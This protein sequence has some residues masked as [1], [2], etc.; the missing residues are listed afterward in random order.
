MHLHLLLAAFTAP[1]AVSGTCYTP[2]PAFPPI[3]RIL[4]KQH[5]NQL[6]QIL[7]NLA[8]NILK[9]PEGWATNKTS[10]SVQVTSKTQTIW[11]HYYTAPILGEYMDSE[12]MPVSGDTAFRVASISKTFTVYGVLLESGIGLDDAVSRW[13]PELLEEKGERSPDWEAITIRSL[14]SQLSG[15][16]REGLC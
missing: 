14:A 11:E 15:I 7:D 10:F 12:P 9:S 4:G 16:S 2:G 3:E 6:S 13:I 5:F 8:K 1:I